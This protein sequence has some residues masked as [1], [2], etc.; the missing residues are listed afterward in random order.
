M[1]LKPPWEFW[2][3]SQPVL[4]SAHSSMSTQLLLS[5]NVNPSPHVFIGDKSGSS[6]PAGVV[7]ATGGVCSSGSLQRYVPGEFSQPYSHSSMISG[8]RHSSTSASIDRKWRNKIGWQISMGW[9]RMINKRDASVDQ[10]I[11]WF[12]FLCHTRGWE[13]NVTPE[14]TYFRFVLIYQFQHDLSSSWHIDQSFGDRFIVLLDKTNSSHHRKNASTKLIIVNR[15]NTTIIVIVWNHNLCFQCKLQIIISTHWRRHLSW[16][17]R[18][19]T[20]IVRFVMLGWMPEY[21][22]M[23]CPC[24]FYADFVTLSI[25]RRPSANVVMS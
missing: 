17:M 20:W 25:Y 7:G 11:A 12:P 22:T 13:R 16:D 3:C 21:R 15:V 19:E 10:R 2:Q 5:S 14:W 4:P 9:D 18:R 8:L 6:W 23:C 1:Q 24:P